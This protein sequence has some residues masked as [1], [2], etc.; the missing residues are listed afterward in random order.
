MN[1]LGAGEGG[2]NRENSND[3]HVLACVKQIDS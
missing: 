3:I 1:T 2:V